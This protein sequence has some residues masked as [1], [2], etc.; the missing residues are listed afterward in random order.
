MSNLTNTANIPNPSIPL[1]D[2]SLYTF[3]M[4]FFSWVFII[5]AFCAIANI[6]SYKYEIEAYTIDK[7]RIQ[8]YKDLYWVYALIIVAGI[9]VPSIMMGVAY[10]AI[11]RA[12]ESTIVYNSAVYNSATNCSVLSVTTADDVPDS[13]TR[14]NA[15]F[16]LSNQT[17]IVGSFEGVCQLYTSCYPPTGRLVACFK[18]ST[19]Y[20]IDAPTIDARYVWKHKNMMIASVVVGAVF[21]VG[22]ICVLVTEDMKLR[23][24]M[25]KRAQIANTIQTSPGA[26]NTQRNTKPLTTIQELQSTGVNLAEIV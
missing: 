10:T 19:G 11:D 17:D 12:W 26:R 16:T 15:S 1:D 9:V 18:T 21:F 14:F 24:D 5:S 20:M 6:P 23:E 25:D 4:L 2:I 13:I 22:M 8:K 7:T 3:I